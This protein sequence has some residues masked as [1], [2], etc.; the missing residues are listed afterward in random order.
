M[1]PSASGEAPG[2]VVQWGLEATAGRRRHHR[3]VRGPGAKG[4]CV[5]DGGLPAPATQ[6]SGVRLGSRW[7]RRRT[8]GWV[9]ERWRRAHGPSWRLPS[10]SRRRAAWHHAEEE[11]GEDQR[12]AGEVERGVMS[13][14]ADLDYWAK[15]SEERREVGWCSAKSGFSR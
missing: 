3:P 13:S 5:D 12:R 7:R 11:I 10:E 2:G 8:L 15:W 14:W 1:R 6:A 4:R 9:G